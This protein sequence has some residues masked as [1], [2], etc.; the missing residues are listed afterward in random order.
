MLG[1]ALAWRGQDKLWRLVWSGS[2]LIAELSE[3]VLCRAYELMEKYRDVPM[4]FADAT[5]VAYAESTEMRKVFTL[6]SDFHIYR[7]HGMHAF[8]VLP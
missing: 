3:P 7:L 4:D 8:E 1:E 6:D 2:L 5:L